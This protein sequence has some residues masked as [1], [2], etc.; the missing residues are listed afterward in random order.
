MRANRSDVEA[1]LDW[2]NRRLSAHAG[3]LELVDLADDGV[4][5]VR[6]A[7]MCR[8]CELRPITMAAT[9]RPGLLAIPGVTR[10]ELVGAKISEEAERRIIESLD[11]GT[12][13]R[14][15]TFIEPQ[16]P[17]TNAEIAP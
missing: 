12:L 11:A 13:E 10:V 7:G 15:T 4:V 2:L 16:S 14:W 5:R 1:R 9:I 6:F 17:D 3:S 8:G